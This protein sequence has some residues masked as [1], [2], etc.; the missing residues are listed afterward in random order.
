MGKK[1]AMTIHTSPDMRE[2][3][4]SWFGPACVFVCVK[5]RH[6]GGETRIEM[7]QKETR[8]WAGA[9]EVLSYTA[10]KSYPIHSPS[11]KHVKTRPRIKKTVSDPHAHIYIY[12]SI[13]LF[14]PTIYIKKHTQLNFTREDGGGENLAKEEDHRHRNDHGH[15]LRHQLV[16]VAISTCVHVCA[17][18]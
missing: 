5:R 9:G 4:S 16:Y 14:H 17:S 1:S 18:L 6:R 7:R 2:P 11:Q 13:H 12:T 15:V 10:P 3:S 8:K